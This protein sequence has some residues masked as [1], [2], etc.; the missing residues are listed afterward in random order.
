MKKHLIQFTIICIFTLIICG[1]TSA[2]YPSDLHFNPSGNELNNSN[3][4][5]VQEDSVG[6]VINSNPT[7]ITR[8]GN[9]SKKT[10]T[11]NKQSKVYLIKLQSTGFNSEHVFVFDKFIVYQKPE[12]NAKWCRYLFNR[13]VTSANPGVKGPED[14]YR[15][16][17]L[18]NVDITKD[19]PSYYPNITDLNVEDLTTT[20]NW[21]K[22][23]QIGST[24][25]PLIGGMHGYEKHVSIK[26]FADN[27]EVTPSVKHVLECDELKIVVVSN[28]LDPKD[29]KTVIAVTTCQYLWNGQELLLNTTYNW[30]QTETVYTAYAAMFPVKRDGSVSSIGQIDGLAEETLTLNRNPILRNNSAKGTTWNHINNLKLSLEVLNPQIALE[31]YLYNGD[32]LNGKTYFNN[33]GAYNKLYI[34]RVHSPDTELVNNTTV[35]TIE[36]R[37]RIWNDYTVPLTIVSTDPKNKAVNV[38]INKIIQITF[39]NPIKTGVNYNKI[40]LYKNGAIIP[41]TKTVSGYN[42]SLY[43]AP[44]NIGIE[45]KIFIPSDSIND[46]SGQKLNENFTFSFITDKTPPILRSIDPSWNKINVP[47][48]R[49]INIL[50]NEPIKFG[51]NYITLQDSNGKYIPTSRSINGNLL[52]INPTIYLAKGTRYTLILH[53]GSIKDISGNTI[54]KYYIS[55]FTTDKP[56]VVKALDPHNNAV[57]VAVD[58]NIN[59]L[60]NE[61]IK[62][63]TNYI[64]LQDSNGK[65]IPTSRSINGNLLIINPTIYLAKGTRYTLILHTSCVKDLNGYGLKQ[66]YIIRFNTKK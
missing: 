33:I 63:G 11:L 19:N 42:L 58:R 35:W 38:A 40:L 4:L 27:L 18:Q 37:Y 54:T 65:Y 2:A 12:N 10:T 59:I 48:D 43:H 50:F 28:L 24:T 51:T 46:I 53:T 17:K 45:Y 66:S 23:V 52:T 61:P 13:I 26:Y 21:E 20:G 39:R 49:N 41:I 6:T 30:K 64:T 8:T 7:A 14:N 3:Y 32:A 1:V 36:S 16:Y 31:N 44:L 9:N 5:N 29:G 57:N 34:T 15:I 22:A 62:F 25:D 56:P 55:P 60:F 47:V